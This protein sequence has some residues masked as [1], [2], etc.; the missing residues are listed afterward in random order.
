MK[1]VKTIM[2]LAF[3]VSSV[4]MAGEVDVQ[5][6]GKTSEGTKAYKI[7]VSGDSYIDVISKAKSSCRS[8]N[9]AEIESNSKDPNDGPSL[10]ITGTYIESGLH[11]LTALCE[12]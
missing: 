8:L 2:V 3:S 10:D 6:K 9:N 4:A 11:G 7:S 12:I 5:Y 1:L